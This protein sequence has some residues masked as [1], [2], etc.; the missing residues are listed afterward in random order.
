M[1]LNQALIQLSEGRK[2]RLPEWIGHWEISTDE[3]LGLIEV[4]TKDGEILYT[5][6]FEKY[7]MR[8]DWEVVPE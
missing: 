1:N 5:P 8:E 4:H 3:S 7:G 2:I 6:H